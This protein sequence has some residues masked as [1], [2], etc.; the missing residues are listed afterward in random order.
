MSPEEQQAVV[1]IEELQLGLV[2][3]GEEEVIQ[4]ECRDL[5]GAAIFSFIWIPR[6]LPYYG[7]PRFRGHRLQW[8]WK[9]AEKKRWLR[10]GP[11]FDTR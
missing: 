3:A 2:A 8:F 11:V 10:I 1:A 9:K 6:S 5:S 7:L 4:F